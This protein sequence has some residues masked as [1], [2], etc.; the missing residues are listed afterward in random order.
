M[1]EWT[2]IMS[3]SYALEVAAGAVSTMDDAFRSWP[4]AL[5][6]TVRADNDFYSQAPHVGASA[7]GSERAIRLLGS[8]SKCF[9]FAS[10]A[11]GQGP[12]PKQGEP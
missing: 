7:C 2:L 3:L 8:S 11:S 9:L 1:V 12:C 4:R 6:I 5:R 10:A